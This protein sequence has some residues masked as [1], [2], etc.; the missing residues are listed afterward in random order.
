MFQFLAGVALLFT[1]ADISA[2]QSREALF[3]L[4]Q[5]EL[6][7]LVDGAM[8]V[9]RGAPQGQVNQV[10]DDCRQ[11]YGWTSEEAAHALVAARLMTE[12]RIERIEL[13]EAGVDFDAVSRVWRALS[14]EEGQALLGARTRRDDARRVAGLLIERLRAAG[15]PREHVVRAGMA[16][17][18]MVQASSVAS[19][20]IRLRLSR[21]SESGSTG[22]TAPAE[23]ATPLPAKPD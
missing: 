16:I 13:I 21:A 23:D 17:A 8:E 7:C 14:A 6:T 9:P 18:K 4:M 11:R 12:T 22:A 2:Q 5:R 20:Y 1:S 19:D 10:L 3:Q 15:V